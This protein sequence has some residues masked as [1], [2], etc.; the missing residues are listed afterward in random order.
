MKD[1]DQS[2]L[3]S[4]KGMVHERI[5]SGDFQLELRHYRAARRTVTVWIS[6]DRRTQKSA[7]Q[8]D[9]VENLADDVE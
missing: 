2:T 4:R 7:K 8:I 1:T 6:L 3:C 5:V 9:P